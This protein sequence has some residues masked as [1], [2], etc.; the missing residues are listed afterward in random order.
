MMRQWLRSYPHYIIICVGLTFIVLLPFYQT[1]QFDFV[2]YDDRNNIMDNKN[3][4][5]GFNRSSV[6]WAF[7]SLSSYN[8]H[9]M[10]WLSLILDYKLYGSSAGGYHV[11]NVLI[12]LVNTILLFLIFVKMTGELWKCG[13]VAALFAIHPLH[14]ES[15]AWIM[16][17][18]DVLSTMFWLLTIVLYVYYTESLSLRYYV[19]VCV[20]F[21]LALMSKPMVVT[22]PV[23]LLLLDYWPLKRFW[24]GDIK[25]SRHLIIEKIPL[26]ILSFIFSAITI[27][28]QGHSG[29][30]Q[31]FDTFPFPDRLVNAIVSYV[32]YIAKMM[33]PVKLAFFYPYPTALSLWVVLFSGALLVAASLIS[34]KCRR[35]APY[36]SMGWLWYLITMFP[37]CGMLQTGEQAMA[38]RY[39]YVP[40]LGLFIIVAWG[41]P[42]LLDKRPYQKYIMPVFA[43]AIIIVLTIQTFY[44]TGTWKNSRTLFEHAITVTEDN[45]V[46]HNNLGRY[47]MEQGNFAE[48]TGHFRKAVNIKPG[49]E[50]FLNNFAVALFRQ[51][52]FDEANSFFVR[53]IA[54]NPL[55]ADSYYNAGDVYF[56][57]GRHIEAAVMYRKALSLRGGNAYAEN[58]LA[59]ILMHMGNYAEAE[60]MLRQALLHRPGYAEAYNNLGVSLGQQGR[61]CQATKAFQTA[62]KHDP[63]YQ[64]AKN[65]ILKLSLDSNCP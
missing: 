22:L 51:N 11:T 40:L 14:V 30:M 53:A 60:L 43:G 8:W 17:R 58:N 4:H 42:D 54:I 9:P 39:T 25:T 31:S 28:A 16:E 63:Q 50:K 20:A 36:L 48:A 34:F 13:F 35:I 10:T 6:G 41:I 5:T 46:A 57:T 52:K 29:A 18:K 24:G 2:H 38:D 32:G 26:F 1:H 3:I 62:L 65:N 21:A 33:L 37:V 49:N 59:V 23:V 47:Y 44:Q 61:L 12:H 56:F 7:T 19:C 15:V 27:Y 64:A 55:F 45:Y